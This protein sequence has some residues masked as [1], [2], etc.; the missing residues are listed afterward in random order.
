MTLLE[1]IKQIG[2][3][4]VNPIKQIGEKA[5]NWIKDKFTTIWD[6]IKN[7]VQR[8]YHLGQDSANKIYEIWKTKKSELFTSD[9]VKKALKFMVD[10]FLYYSPFELHLYDPNGVPLL[11]PPLINYPAYHYAGPGTRVEERIEKGYNG[12]NIMDKQ[13]KQHDLVYSETGKNE[14]SENKQKRLTADKALLEKAKQLVAT[15]DRF[16]DI[17]NGLVVYY[18]ISKKIEIGAY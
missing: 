18:A 17:I 7:I 6:G 5:K 8:I 10:K 9:F 3:K 12:I 11:K 15:T 16:I 14:T 1:R 4:I 2:M 13:A